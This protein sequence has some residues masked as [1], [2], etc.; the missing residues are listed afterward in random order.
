MIILDLIGNHYFLDVAGGRAQSGPSLKKAG[1]L[2]G[3][4]F[5]GMNA[6]GAEFTGS[7]YEVAWK[8]AGADQYV[9]WETDGN[10]N[11]LFDSGVLIGRECD[12]AGVGDQLRSGPQ[13]RWPYRPRDSS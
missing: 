8:I 12:A 5:S 7:G 9:V 3:P 10:G 6:I 11:Y 4:G 13:R 2:V 1:V